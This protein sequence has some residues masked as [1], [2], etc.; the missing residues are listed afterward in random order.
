MR[1]PERFVRGVDRAQGRGIGCAQILTNAHRRMFRAG[2]MVSLVRASSR[3][4]ANETHY[5]ALSRRRWK[6]QR[7]A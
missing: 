3:K 5:A 7:R 1:D 6:A 2:K 4:R